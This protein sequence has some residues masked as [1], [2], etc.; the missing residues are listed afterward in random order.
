VADLI[1]DAGLLDD[2]KTVAE[3]LLR[4][5]P[6]CVEPLISRWLGQGARYAEV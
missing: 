4:D 3:G 5:D 2:V 6:E 1:R